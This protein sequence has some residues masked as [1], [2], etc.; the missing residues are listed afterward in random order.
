MIFFRV[1]IS[2]ILLIF[3]HSFIYAERKTLPM[4]E[5][6]EGRESSAYLPQ[7]IKNTKAAKG[8]GDL[9][10]T[11]PVSVGIEEDLSEKEAVLEGEDLS[12]EEL[13]EE[14]KE[15][16]EEF[17]LEEPIEELTPQKK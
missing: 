7:K 12:E 8:S 2:V 6:T 11:G 5:D 1:I 15:L 13:T 9:I 4:P 10:L 3:V 14:S 16:I 17:K